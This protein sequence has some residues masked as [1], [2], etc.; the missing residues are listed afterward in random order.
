MRVLFFNRSAVPLGGGMNRLVIDTARRLG[1][2]GHEVALVHGREGGKFDGTGYIFDDLD[3]RSLPHE[4]SALRLEAIIEDFSP[5]IIQLH[6]VGNTFLDGWLAARCPTVRFVHNHDFYCSGRRLTLDHPPRHC[7]RVHGRACCLSHFVNGCGSGNPVVDFLRYRAVSR[8]LGALRNVNALQ[9]MSSALRNQLVANGIPAERIVSLPPCAPAPPSRGASPGGM[10][11]SI[12]HVGG[13]LGHK[14]VWMVVRMLR[15]LPR[16]VQLVFAGGGGEKD[17]LEAH[18][19]RR[20][21]G[22]RVRIVGE[23]TPAQWSLLYRESSMVIMPV[24]WNEPLGLDGL[25]AM[26]HGKPVVAFD[27]PGIREWL[28]D[29]ETG[30]IVPFGERAVFRDTVL[31]LLDDPARLRSM[32]RRAF[33]VWDARFRPER[34]ITELVACYEKVRAEALR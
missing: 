3:G 14:G 28:A 1:G 27:T 26:A 15:Q 16:D 31:G 25:A 6:G 34:H 21:L 13:L 24:L 17:L 12:L 4:R 22:E 29:G 32:G 18:V 20:G 5:H 9:V 30:V 23:P 11:R 10:V 2:A 19:R 33:E 7:N 8:S